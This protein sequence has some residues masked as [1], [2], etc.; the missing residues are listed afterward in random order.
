MGL[1]FVAICLVICAIAVAPVQGAPGQWVWTIAA[2]G[3]GG[4]N[5][6][7]AAG[8][9]Q[10]LVLTGTVYNLDSDNPLIFNG[11]TLKTDDLRPRDPGLFQTHWQTN[12]LMEVPEAFTVAPG[13]S[14]PFV[15]GE[16]QAGSAAPGAVFE[17]KLIG[18]AAYDAVAADPEDLVSA[19]VSVTVVPE[20]SSLAIVAA[21]AGTTLA[22]VRR[23]R[24]KQG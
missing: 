5:Y 10:P 18:S 9:T 6:Q 13:S 8:S 1:R 2:A 3:S 12:P 17:F 20:P 15:I 21:G 23:R 19:T 16:F 7:M 24:E 22:A 11:I 4:L 14:Q